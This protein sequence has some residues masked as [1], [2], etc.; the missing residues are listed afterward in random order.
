MKDL[1]AQYKAATGVEFSNPSANQLDPNKVKMPP[2]PGSTTDTSALSPEA[3][4]LKQKIVAQGDK[5]RQLKSVN[6]AK[7]CTCKNIIYLASL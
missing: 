6:T 2:T 7:V 4:A 5:I 1:K 3:E